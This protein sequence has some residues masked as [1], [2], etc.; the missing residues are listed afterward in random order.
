MSKDTPVLPSVWTL[1]R[2]CVQVQNAPT[3]PSLSSQLLSHEQRYHELE[4]SLLPSPSNTTS[5]SPAQLYSPEPSITPVTMMTPPIIPSSVSPP[6]YY[7]YSSSPRMSPPY[8]QLLATPTRSPEL[9]FDPGSI[10]PPHSHSSGYGHINS[11]HLQ[12][13]KLTNNKI[14]KAPLAPVLPI[15]CDDCGSSFSRIADLYRH[16]RT[17]HS[18]SPSDKSSECTGCGK[19]F[20]R[21]DSLK[22]HIRKYCKK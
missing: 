14:K 19:S 1:F 2:S 15:R 6:R 18:N 7:S 21:P 22:R 3:L 12:P 4:Q 17:H 11:I 8:Q 13:L 10:S 9:T 5:F 16:N 20:N